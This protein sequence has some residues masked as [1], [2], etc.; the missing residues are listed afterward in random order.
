MYMHVSCSLISAEIIQNQYDA[1]LKKLSEF[2]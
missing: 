2:I 1:A